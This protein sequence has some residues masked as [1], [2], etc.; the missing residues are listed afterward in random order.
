[1]HVHNDKSKQPP[2]SRGDPDSFGD[3]AVA[4]LGTLP[5]RL[6]LLKELGLTEVKSLFTSSLKEVSVTLYHVD[7]SSRFV[8]C[9]RRASQES[10]VW[11]ECKPSLDEGSALDYTIRLTN[12]LSHQGSTWPNTHEFSSESP[13]IPFLGN[14]S[15]LIGLRRLSLTA[16]LSERYGRGPITKDLLLDEVEFEDLR[17]F[18]TGGKDV[19]NS[20]VLTL[21]GCKGRNLILHQLDLTLALRSC[22]RSGTSSSTVVEYMDLLNCN[23]KGNIAKGCTVLKARFQKVEGEIVLEALNESLSSTEAVEIIRNFFPGLAINRPPFVVSPKVAADIEAA[24]KRKRE[25]PLEVEQPKRSI[26]SRLTRLFTPDQTRAGSSS[27]QPAR[28][29]A[30]LNFN[31]LGSS[32]Q[33]QTSQPAVQDP[34]K[35]FQSDPDSMEGERFGDPSGGIPSASATKWD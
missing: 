25:A 7:K 24:Q 10:E 29:E 34:Y 15:H 20:L 16:S 12:A 9:C 4:A 6:Q 27:T 17:C 31:S 19:K 13:I 28:L 8:V 30:P 5:P 1:M 33:Y 32:S 3:G 14:D 21:E 23:V 26:W 22:D 2:V 11:I 35:K 18:G